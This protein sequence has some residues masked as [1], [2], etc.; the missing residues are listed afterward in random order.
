MYFA[1][2]MGKSIGK[3]RSTN[4]SGI[5]SRKF[6]DHAKQSATGALET[7][8]KRANQKTAEATGD[9]IGNKI[10]DRITKV[11]KTSKQNNPETVTNGM[12]KKYLKKDTYLQKKDRKLLMI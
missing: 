1:E 7:A 8:S 2:N 4:L 9:S 10:A 6:L 3:N 12:I 11:S 5:Y